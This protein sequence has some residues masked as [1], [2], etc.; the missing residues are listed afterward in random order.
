MSKG[1]KNLCSLSL[2]LGSSLQELPFYE[3]FS[4]RSS[5]AGYVGIEASDLGLDV[6][7][8]FSSSVQD[9]RK[10]LSSN[11][12]LPSALYLHLT[13]G[14]RWEH[15]PLNTTNEVKLFV[16][17]INFLYNFNNTTIQKVIWELVH[18]FRV[19]VVWV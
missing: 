1:C 19:E 13:A 14:A 8:M 6:E 18:W 17:S 16:F 7:V 5:H 4:L 10:V 12:C 2:Q 3:I 11:C 9:D 15:F